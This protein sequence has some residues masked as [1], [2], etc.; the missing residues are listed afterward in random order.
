MKRA[1][2]LAITALAGI[3]ALPLGL[4]IALLIRCG[5]GGPVLVRRPRSGRHGRPFEMLTFRTTREVRGPDEPDSSRATRLGALLRRT[6][7]EQLPQLWNVV[8]GEMAVIG[9]RPVP[10]EQAPP[11]SPGRRGRLDV[12]PGLTGWAQVSGRGPVTRS[13]RIAL[14]L[15]YVEHR[16]LRLDL[17]ILAL[18]VRLL[19]RPEGGPAAVPAARSGPAPT[20][21]APL[22][23]PR[24][25]AGRPGPS[26]RE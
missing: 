7:L 3:T 9:P 10:P 15:W 11:S 19:L 20:P 23:P 2:D 8:R 17:R 1:G 22:P 18:T 4:L 16:S 26:R 25:A 5:T 6:G 21:P 12:R 14:D 24:Q 13:Q